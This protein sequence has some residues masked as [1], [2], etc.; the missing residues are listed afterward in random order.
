M[1]GAALA[2]V[3]IGRLIYSA[4][5][6]PGSF[7]P[8]FLGFVGIYAFFNP[9]WLVFPAVLIRSGF[10]K[11]SDPADGFDLLMCGLL[12]ALWIWGFWIEVFLI[13]KISEIG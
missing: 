10:A 13:L 1:P 2:A 3:H 8:L 5:Y 4:Y 11:S 9:G 7:D 12:A 6:Y